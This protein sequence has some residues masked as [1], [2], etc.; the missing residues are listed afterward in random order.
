MFFQV[1]LSE[2]ILVAPRVFEADSLYRCTRY[3]WLLALFASLFFFQFKIIIGIQF[4][5]STTRMQFETIVGAIPMREMLYVA[6][7]ESQNEKFNGT[8]SA[9]YG[10]WD[11]D[12]S[13]AKVVT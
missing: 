11:W 4:A 2:S 12:M 13:G 10:E 7:I 9:L 6:H 1:F 3:G 8:F 5:A